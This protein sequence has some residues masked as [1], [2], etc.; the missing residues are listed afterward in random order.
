[1]SITINGTTGITFNDA[2][3]QSKAADTF[4]R[5]WHNVT[6]SRSAGA[7]YTNNS[8]VWMMVVIWGATNVNNTLYVD[9]NVASAASS[10]PSNRGTVSALVPPGSTYSQTGGIQGWYELY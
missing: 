3:V 9:G 2:S 10:D 7:T 8:G 4:G 5:I 1:M 6:G